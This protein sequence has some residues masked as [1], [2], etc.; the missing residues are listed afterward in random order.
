MTTT[1]YGDIEINYIGDGLFVSIITIIAKLFEKLSPPLIN[2]IL[3]T[4]PITYVCMYDIPY[5]YVARC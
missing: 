5:I 4:Y 3:K 1:G 2:K